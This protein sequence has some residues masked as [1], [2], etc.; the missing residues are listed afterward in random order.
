MAR[1]RIKIC[2]ITRPQDAI[3]AA[4]AGA[5]ATGMMLHAGAAPRRISLDLAKQILAA[6]PPMVSAVGVFVD[7]PAQ[8][9]IDIAAALGLSYVQLHGNE[10]PEQVAALGNLQV[11]KAIH[12]GD[13]GAL[14]EWR[15][16]PQ[17][18]RAFL[19]ESGRGGSGIESDWQAIAAAVH[20]HPALAGRS[21]VAAGGLRPDNVA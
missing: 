13:S 1:T 20:D 11:I 2:G 17:H 12:L 15:D 8:L 5:D 10:T 7:A 14:D 3:A 4:H 18:L 21:L 6:L 19:L 9:I 16:P